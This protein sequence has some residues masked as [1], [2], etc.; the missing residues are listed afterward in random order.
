MK[1]IALEGSGQVRQKRAEKGKK[2]RVLC[3]RGWEKMKG[4]G[5]ESEKGECKERGVIKKLRSG[6]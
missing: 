2:E 5:R 1:K 6:W 3:G 4:A